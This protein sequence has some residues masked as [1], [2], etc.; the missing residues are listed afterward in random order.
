MVSEIVSLTN[1]A[2]LYVRIH[3]RMVRVSAIA[4]SE[5]DANAYLTHHRGQGVIATGAGLIFIASNDDLGWRA[6]KEKP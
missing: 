1:G 2:Q 4:E 5:V 3:G 6:P